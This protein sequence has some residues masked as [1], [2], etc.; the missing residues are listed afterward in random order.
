MMSFG[1]AISDTKPESNEGIHAPQPQPAPPVQSNR[2]DSF[3]DL[4]G[5]FGHT[6]PNPAT[7]QISTPPPQ[8][9]P[10]PTQPQQDQPTVTPPVQQ[11][12][13]VPNPAPPNVVPSQPESSGELQT[14]YASHFK[15]GMPRGLHKMNPNNVSR[16]EWKII[17]NTS[18]ILTEQPGTQGK[19]HHTSGN[20]VLDAVHMIFLDFDENRRFFDKNNRTAQPL[21]YSDDC[22]TNSGGQ[23]F[24][25]FG[26]QCRSCIHA[27]WK[28]DKNNPQP[29]CTHFFNYP[30]L[31]EQQM[32]EQLP[33]P[34]TL[35]LSKTS[36]KYAKDFNR[37]VFGTGQ[38]LYFYVYKV[39]TFLKQSGNGKSYVPVFEC[40]RETTDEER[41]LCLQLSRKLDMIL[42]PIYDQ[43]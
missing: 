43:N 6:P 11:T 20:Q 1:P 39:S 3:D 2:S 18:D 30:V 8:A 41:E 7:V 24:K 36:I 27:Q 37:L 26:Q 10:A 14:K 29:D 34:S 23:L 35:V 13:P 9:T 21:C 16:A 5:Q 40:V 42:Q 12:R 38:P 4:A 19:L 17:Q 25:P 15:D 28:E 22:M 31:V 32:N 33:I